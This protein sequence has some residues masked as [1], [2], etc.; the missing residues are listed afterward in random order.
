[1]LDIVHISLGEPSS[2]TT[3]LDPRTLAYLGYKGQ[4]VF[5]LIESIANFDVLLPSPIPIGSAERA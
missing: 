3:F 5:S 4:V 2:E 1:M